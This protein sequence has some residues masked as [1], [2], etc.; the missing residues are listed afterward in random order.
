KSPRP[1]SPP[2]NVPENVT[3]GKLAKNGK[4]STSGWPK[5]DSP[6]PQQVKIRPPN[7]SLLS[8]LVVLACFRELNSLVIVVSEDRAVVESEW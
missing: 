6:R 5:N 1:I 7:T 3:P 2:Q 4:L 8:P